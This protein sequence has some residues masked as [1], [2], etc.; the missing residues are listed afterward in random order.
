M[1]EAAEPFPREGARLVVGEEQLH[2]VDVY[3][4]EQDDQLQ[5]ELRRRLQKSLEKRDQRPFKM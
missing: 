4:G 3:P 5:H 2:V 1:K